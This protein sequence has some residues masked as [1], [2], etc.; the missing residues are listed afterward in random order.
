MIDINIEAQ[1]ALDTTGY[2]V[3][4]HYP[5]STETLP[6]VSFYMISESGDMSADNSE[7]FQTG[8]I[9]IDIF[10]DTP[11]Q[12]GEMALNINAAMSAHGWCRIMSMDVPEETDGVFHKAMR[13]TKSFFIG[14][15]I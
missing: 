9:G 5:Q 4:F 6:V 10:T 13:Y 14:G 15:N 1:R 8:V 2:K 11:M 12:G 7:M 3:V